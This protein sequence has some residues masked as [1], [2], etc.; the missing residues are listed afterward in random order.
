MAG[1]GWMVGETDINVSCESAGS[2]A[3]AEAGCTCNSRVQDL[4]SAGEDS[5]GSQD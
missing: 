1:S 4:E 5:K 3:V 2:L